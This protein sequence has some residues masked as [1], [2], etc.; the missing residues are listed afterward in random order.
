[1]P[2]VPASIHDG[3]LWV[4]GVHVVTAYPVIDAVDLGERVV[5]L[6]DPDADPRSW[7]TFRNLVGLDRSGSTS[8]IADTAETTTGDHWTKIA[9]AVPLRAHAWAGYLCTLD[10]STGRIVDRVFTK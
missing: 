4:D 5:V 2:H 3:E 1:M 8:W 6:Y 10:P 9:S 7:G